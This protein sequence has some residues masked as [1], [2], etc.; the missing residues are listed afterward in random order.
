MKIEVVILKNTCIHCAMVRKQK[1]I[2]EAY[3]EKRKELKNC[4]LL[5]KEKQVK[6][7]I[8]KQLELF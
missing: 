3:C 2:N 8:N 1:I 6:E 5:Y 4:W 7:I